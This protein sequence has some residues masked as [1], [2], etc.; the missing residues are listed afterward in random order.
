[1]YWGIKKDNKKDNKRKA[2]DLGDEYYKYSK[3]GK[4]PKMLCNTNKNIYT[5]GN[6]IHYTGSINNDNIEEV[7]KQT[8]KIINK[9]HKKYEDTDDKLELV[10]IVDSLGGQVSSILKLVDFMGLVKQKYPY[11]TFTSILTGQCAS[12]GT[13][14]CIACDKRL[15]TKNAK[16]MVHQLSSGNSGKY[17]QLK[18]YT[19]H[20]TDLH[21]TLVNI[22][23]E[24]CGKTKEEIEAILD[25]ETWYN[26]EQYLAEGFIDAIV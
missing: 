21:N 13:V 3:P 8:T 1:M 20:L 14:F 23:V 26:A 12:A 18:S 24:K 6:E 15:M 7:I 16:S 11:V 10:Y 9:N 5:F 22:Y 4:M 19:D 25:R 2:S 17:T